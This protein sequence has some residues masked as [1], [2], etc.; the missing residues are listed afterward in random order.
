MVLKLPSTWAEGQRA[1]CDRCR[2]FARYALT[3][4]EKKLY[5][6]VFAAAGYQVGEC[7]RNIAGSWPIDDLEFWCGEFKPDGK[8]VE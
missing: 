6:E 2:F 1:S 4:E 5:D 3:E 7:R 8:H